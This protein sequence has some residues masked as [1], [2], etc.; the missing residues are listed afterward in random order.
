M[1]E[2]TTLLNKLARNIDKV[3]IR[4]FNK[5]IENFNDLKAYFENKDGLEIGGPS[6]IFGPDGYIPVYPIARTVDGCNFSTHTVWE[7]TIQEGPNYRYEDQLLGYQHIMEATDL[8]NILPEVY[9]FVLSSHSLEHVANPLKALREWL[10]VLK[11]GGILVLVV[12]DKQ[13]TFDQHRPYTTFEHLLDDYERNVGED[14]MTHLEEILSLH[15]LSRDLPAGDT[16]Q[17]KA[18]SLKNAENRCLHHHVFNFE[19]LEQIC[20]HLN[21]EVVQKSTAWQYHMILFGRK[22]HAVDTGGQPLISPVE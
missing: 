13:Y 5:K 21:I 2:K 18:R 12:P 11:T 17:F 16:L 6:D 9:D 7:N 15:D 4:H 14:D 8:S 19:T 1:A 3:S 20:Q 10:R 22:L